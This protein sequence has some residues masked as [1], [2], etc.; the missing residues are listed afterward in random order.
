VARLEREVVGRDEPRACEQHAAGRH[1]VVADQP[2]DQVRERA[3]HLRG[4]GLAR[5]QLAPVA[6]DDPHANHQRDLP[7]VGDE[8]R[9]PDRARACE[10]LR[11]R[12]V[13]R[14]LALDRAGGDV[15]ADRQAGEG[16]CWTEDDAHLGLGDVPGRVSADA[17]RLAR[18]DRP[19]TA[20]VLH[21]QLGTS[22][23]V[24]HRVHVL[25]GALLDPRVAATRVGD[26]GA[27]DLGRLD[28]DR[29]AVS[30][31]LF[32]RLGRRLDD[33]AVGVVTEA[34]HQ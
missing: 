27:P 12:D 14:V 25:D 10:R 23:V 2:L 28:R 17:D 31:E 6:V 13:E 32:R 1:R 26:A 24:N 21:E 22:G 33:P 3:A 15:V 19:A 30:V 34:E 16:S 4:G 11:L 20:G 7:V 29:Q 9:R 18:T 8:D 5:E